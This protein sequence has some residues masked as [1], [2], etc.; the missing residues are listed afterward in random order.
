MQK[1]H[2]SSTIKKPKAKRSHNNKA[3]RSFACKK[4]TRVAQPKTRKR[5]LRARKSYINRAHETLHVEKTSRSC[6]IESRKMKLKS[7]EKLY[8]HS[9]KELCTRT[10]CKEAP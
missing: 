1:R 2:N 3:H 7:N 6:T 10:K 9:L 5:K 4:N 8:E